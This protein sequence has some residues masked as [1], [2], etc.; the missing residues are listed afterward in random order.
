MLFYGASGYFALLPGVLPQECPFNGFVFTPS[1]V[2]VRVVFLFGAGAHAH[3]H[4][5]C[6][7]TD[8]LTD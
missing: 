8:W 2:D 3:T 6:S 4:E 7:L 1:I 5:L